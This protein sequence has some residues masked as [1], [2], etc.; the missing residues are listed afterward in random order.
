[1]NKVAFLIPCTSKRRPEWQ[2]M[3][4]TYLYNYT[5]KTFLLTMNKNEKYTYVFYIGYDPGDR[6]FSVKE[7]QN[8][9]HRMSSV[10]S[11]VKFIFIELNAT[12]GH[13]T[14]MWNTLY[15]IAYDNGCEYFYQCGDDIVFHTKNWLEDSIS[16]LKYHKDIGIS[17]P[18]NNNQRILTQALFSRKHMEIFGYL[19]PETILNWC[20]DDWY[21][22]IY[23][24]EYF[25]PLH[26]HYCSNNGG[27]PR[28]DIDGDPN[29][30]RF[31]FEQKL[32]QLRANT[33]KLIPAHKQQIKNY[34]NLHNKL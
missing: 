14:K 4:Y 20:C 18:I 1:M 28:Y 11:R 7:Q 34:I 2:S 22:W 23:N 13:V 3:K 26:Q 29:F 19:F 6:I 17:G 25:Y 8:E 16:R 33:T 27:R 15:K 30:E 10:F 5:V 24:P 12:P 21:N 9:L 32:R 31:N